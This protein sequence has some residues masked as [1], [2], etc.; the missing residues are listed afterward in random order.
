MQW[1]TSLAI[2]LI[3]TSF[4][5]H[6]VDTSAP[7][8]DGQLVSFYAEEA[9]VTETTAKERLSLLAAAR[10][11]QEIISSEEWF[12]GMYVE[13]TP[14]FQ[15]HILRSSSSGD[16]ASYLS[17]YLVTLAP[18]IAVHD[19]LYSWVTLESQAEETLA[20][21]SASDIKA[22][23][24]ID[25]HSNGIKLRA[26]DASALSAEIRA[27]GLRLPSNIIVEQGSFIEPLVPIYGGMSLG[28]CTSGFGL[29]RPDG[30]RAIS[31]AGHCHPNPQYYQ[32][33]QLPW[34]G[35]Q[36]QGSWDIGWLSPRSFTPTNQINNGTDYWSITS[37]RAAGSQLIG[38]VACKNGRVTAVQC[39]FIRSKAIAPSYLLNP[40]ADFIALGS[41]SM[42][43]AQGDSG[44]PVWS[45][46]IALGVIS[47][48]YTA[49][50]EYRVVYMAADR[51]FPAT[52]YYIL[53][54]P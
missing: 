17:P 35:Y 8:S 50:G 7:E 31:T 47:G 49:G 18:H 5:A 53:V 41:T 27:K 48:G 51:V 39:G 43:G 26:P 28:H 40:N 45:A 10:E 36:T 16:I 44:G 37:I 21:L 22:D 24:E 20:A 54:T 14:R 42:R 9:L 25:I 3:S 1:K 32:G 12:A 6:A 11:L 33:S 4:T 19:V 13:H 30:A 52:G 2:A 15:I 34:L 29:V 46:S 38:D 23:V